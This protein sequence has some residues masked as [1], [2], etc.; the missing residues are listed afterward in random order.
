MPP[1]FSYID[2]VAGLVAQMT[3]GKLLKSKN[4]KKTKKAF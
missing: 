4:K 2:M 3:P 1:E